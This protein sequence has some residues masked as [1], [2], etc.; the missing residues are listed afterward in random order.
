MVRGAGAEAGESDAGV[1]EILAA[2][3]TASESEGV[4][5]P[6][7]ELVADAALTTH[8]VGGTGTTG[9]ALA[10]LLLGPEVFEVAVRGFRGVGGEYLFGEG[11]EDE[12]LDVATGVL[13]GSTSVAVTDTS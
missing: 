13:F 11:H 5:H 9:T 6:A 2:G 4:V 8:T 1:A 7:E 12:E 10:T 3:F